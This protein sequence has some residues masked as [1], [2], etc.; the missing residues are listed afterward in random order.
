MLAH[1]RETMS[2]RRV[3]KHHWHGS[4][5]TEREIEPSPMVE[6]IISL[7]GYAAAHGWHGLWGMV[8]PESWPRSARTPTTST[9]P[10]TRKVS[11]RSWRPGDI[12][13]TRARRTHDS[14]ITARPG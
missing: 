12:P 2:F 14:Y 1:R 4:P 10:S 7:D 11:E 6:V 8:E 5:T 3:I 13:A 9:S